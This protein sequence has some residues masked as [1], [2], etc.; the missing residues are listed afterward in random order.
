MRAFTEP[1][2]TAIISLTPCV[3]IMRLRE[4]GKTLLTIACNLG[5]LWFPTAGCQH[6]VNYSHSN[7]TA[8][9][10][11]KPVFRGL[12]PDRILPHTPFLL[13][14]R[15]CR[16]SDPWPERWSSKAKAGPSILMSQG[17][18]DE[19]FHNHWCLGGWS[20]GQPVLALRG[21]MNTP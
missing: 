5:S 16:C 12:A 21:H 19:S 13:P 9:S 3:L 10:G 7:K 17:R 14:Y 20:L 8:A 1:G 11:T 18:E 4:K 2:H 15:F 6:H